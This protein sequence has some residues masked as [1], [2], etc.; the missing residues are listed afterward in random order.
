MHGSRRWILLLSTL[1]Y[2]KTSDNNRWQIYLQPALLT[3]VSEIKI[4]WYLPGVWNLINRSDYNV[5]DFVDA[6][7]LYDPP[8][9]EETGFRRKV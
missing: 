9:C 6:D 2:F 1:W 5:K 7:V 4:F 3:P 8:N